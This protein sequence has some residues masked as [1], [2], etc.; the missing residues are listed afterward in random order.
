MK[1]NVEQAVKKTNN[2]KANV[3]ILFQGTGTT[4]KATALKLKGM[5]ESQEIPNATVNIGANNAANMNNN[6]NR[7]SWNMNMPPMGFNQQAMPQTIQ[8][9]M[10]QA[11]TYIPLRALTAQGYVPQIQMPQMWGQ[12]PQFNTQQ[13]Q[14]M[15]PNRVSSFEEQQAMMEQM[16]I[17]FETMALRIS[18]RKEAAAISYKKYQLSQKQSETNAAPANSTAPTAPAKSAQ[19]PVAATVS[20]PTNVIAPTAPAKSMTAPEAP[21]TP[22]EK[23]N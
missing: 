16:R 12:M 13:R 5:V 9:P 4:D 6:G 17:Q 19:A 22:E 1:T 20:A 3:N 18:E 14:A 11:M 15:A 7:S 8:Q 23:T 2:K 21:S 10:P